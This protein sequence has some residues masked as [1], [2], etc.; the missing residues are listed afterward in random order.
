MGEREIFFNALD[1]GEPV[2]RAAFLDAAC[3]GDAHLRR[4]IEALLHADVEAGQFMKYSVAEQLSAEVVPHSLPGYEIGEI[5]GRGGMGEVYRAL[6]RRLG[7]ELAIKCLRSHFACDALVMQR[8]LS[9][10][11]ITASLQHPGIPPVHEVGT[12]PDGRPFMAMKLIAGRSLAELLSQRSDPA[13]DRGT[14]IS[15]FESVC[16]AVGFAHSRG[17]L[18]RDLKPANVMVGAFGEVQV[19]DWGLARDSSG[20]DLQPSE[21]T[22]SPDT[23]LSVSGETVAFT[24]TDRPTSVANPYVKTIAGSVMGTP[25]FMAPEQARGEAA[26]SRSDVYGLGAMLCIILTGSPPF[27]GVDTLQTLVAN[28]EGDVTDARARLAACGADPELLALCERCL[29]LQPDDR[30]AD[31]GQV[32]AAIAEWQTQADERSRQDMVERATFDARVAEERKRRQ[33]LFRAAAIIV[34]VIAVGGVVSGWLAV[35]ATLAERKTAEQ[36]N[37]TQIAENQAQTEAQHALAAERFA[38]QREQEARQSAAAAVAAAAEAKAFGDFLENN[39]LAATRPAGTQKGI[40]HDIKVSDALQKAEADITTVFAGRPA[41]EARARHAV[42]VTWRNL[43]R[44]DRAVVNLKRAVELWEALEGADHDLTLESMNSLGVTYDEMGNWAA[45]KPLLERVVA[46]HAARHG[47]DNV[48][49]LF[50]TTN[51]GDVL[52]H[53]KEYAAAEAMYKRVLERQQATLPPDHSNILRTETALGVL[54]QGKGDFATARTFYERVF[55]TQER[56]LGRGHP[57][58]LYTMACLGALELSQNRTAAEQWFTMALAGNL[59]YHG[60]D[61]PDT[62]YCK[63][64]L[65][66]LHR[67]AGRLDLALPLLEDAM[68]LMRAQYGEG[69]SETLATTFEYGVCLYKMGRKSEAL[70]LLEQAYAKR[71]KNPDFVS[72]AVWLQDIYRSISRNR[73]AVRVL[74]ERLQE[75]RQQLK[76]GSEE[77]GQLLGDTA[78]ML[79]LADP[80]AA[81]P[82]LRESLA[83]FQEKTPNGWL[84]ARAR[85]MIG[86]VLLHQKNYAAAEAELLRAYSELKDREASIPPQGRFIFPDTIDRLIRVSAALGK[87]DETAKWRAD[88]A[89]YPLETAPVPRQQ[90]S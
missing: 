38:G 48:K 59:K 76:T 71:D 9:E 15:V 74:Q 20:I 84:P 61:H 14:F 57:N 73:D 31:A 30:P 43:G 12:L 51:L 24:A 80:E 88:R 6:D 32:A 49:T 2:E 46:V 56:T 22:T 70:P 11:R 60:P 7:R 28:A 40:G 10:A 47:A 90:K 4:R 41:A 26:D 45:A 81:E 16:Q 23:T 77:L 65:G 37:R 87:T 25:G 64:S 68:R 39:F 86:G 82:V 89:K 34:S 21:R 66:H 52:L 17:V 54:Y 8:F 18:H 42:G 62:A 63:H 3:A 27:G 1:Y 50:I 33:T 75:G 5:I 44:Y 36:L 69:H 19:M 29:S 85:S 35:R 67:L 55:Q 72:I 13:H 78:E 58:I 79:Y 53:Q 83:H